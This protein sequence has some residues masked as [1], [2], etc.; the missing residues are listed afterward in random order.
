MSV[1]LITGCSTGIGFATAVFLAKNGHKVYAT[2]RDP[3]KTALSS[4][5]ASEDLPIEILSLDVNSDS[6]VSNAFNQV[7]RKEGRIDVLVNNAGISGLGAVEELPLEV[8]RN[9]METN[10]FGTIRCIKAVL[11]SMREKR[12]GTIINISSVAGKVY[13]YFH[14]TYAPTKAAVEALSECLAQEVTPLGIKVALVEPGVT[15]TAIF[16]KGYSVPDKTNYPNVKRFLSFFAASLE[17]HVQPDEIAKV[18]LDIIDGRSTKFRNPAGPDAE[19]LIQWRATQKDEDWIA[20]TSIDDETWITAM[21]QGM[22]LNVR[23]YMEDPSRIQFEAEP[24][25][26]VHKEQ[27]EDS[28]A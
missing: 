14:A 27:H 6:S 17:N 13:S 24:K 26:S 2:M 23:T 12:Q 22:H 21:E 1:V 11:P 9:D 10:Y 19:P 7:L 3:S 5:I 16:T 28:L 4:L 18:V 25:E 8:F 20:S 15:D